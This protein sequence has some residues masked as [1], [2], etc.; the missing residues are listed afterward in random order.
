MDNWTGA[1][2][3]MSGANPDRP[4]VRRCKIDDCDGATGAPGARRGWCRKHYRRWYLHGDPLW[5]PKVRSVSLCGI[6]GCEGVQWSRGWCSIHYC[7]W[8]RHGDPLYP[9]RKDIAA[10]PCSIDGCEGI[11]M[12]RGWCA[13]HYSRWQRHSDPLWVR[14]R[15]AIGSQCGIEGC[16]HLIDRGSARGWCAMHYQRWYHHGDPLFLVRQ[17]PY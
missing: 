1:T 8:Q 4:Q 5:E 6:D 11:L 15:T 7:R 10:A 2:A 9:L 14:E 17:Q 12:A 3:E 13:K 16:D